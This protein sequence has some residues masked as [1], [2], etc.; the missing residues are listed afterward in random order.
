[1]AAKSNI[2][3]SKRELAQAKCEP[4]TAGTKPLE[5]ERLEE[6]LASVSQWQL[7]DN[8][9]MISRTFKFA[10]WGG[11]AQFVDRVAQLSDQQGHHPEIHLSWG[12][13]LIELS[14][15]KIHGLSEND[16]ILAAKIDQML[17]GSDLE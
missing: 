1:M 8:S 16:V 2:A 11:A 6:L 14:T 10:D 17:E 4:C 5:G 7:A 12:K 3:V 9:K 15:H 13:V